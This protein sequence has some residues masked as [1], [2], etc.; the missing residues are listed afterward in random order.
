MFDRMRSGTEKVTEVGG[1]KFRITILEPIHLPLHHP[2][3]Q[4]KKQTK[5]LV[6]QDFIFM[7]WVF[8]NHD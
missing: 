8:H 1:V 7:R 2:P 3:V 4:L 6:I 5:T